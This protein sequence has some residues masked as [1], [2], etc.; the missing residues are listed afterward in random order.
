MR[1]CLW[2]L[3][4]LL[5]RRVNTPAGADGSRLSS[6]GDVSRGPAA[7]ARATRR[8]RHGLDAGD[9]A[10]VNTMV[11]NLYSKCFGLLLERV[12]SREGFLRPPDRKTLELVHHELCQKYRQHVPISH[13]WVG[14]SNV[15]HFLVLQKT[16]VL[17]PKTLTWEATLVDLPMHLHLDLDRVTSLTI[18]RGIRQ[19]LGGTWFPA[20]RLRNL[21]S[22]TLDDTFDQ[23]MGGDVFPVTL[24]VL[25]F[26]DKFNKSTADMVFP[27]SLKKLQFGKAF[28]QP[29]ARGIL[30]PSLEWLEFH[31]HGKFNQHIDNVGLPDRMRHLSLGGRYNRSIRGPWLEQ[32]KLTHL[33][34]S[35][36]TQNVY[37]VSWPRNLTDVGMGGLFLNRL[38]DMALPPSVVRMEFAGRFNQSLVGVPWPP[39]LEELH[40]RYCEFRRSLV[41]DIIRD[42]NDDI[43]GTGPVTL[44]DSLHTLSLGSLFDESLH[45]VTWPASLRKLS[46]G[47]GFTQE[48]LNVAWP[49]SLRHVTLP[50]PARAT[51]ATVNG[52]QITWLWT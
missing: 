12:A 46:F 26:G 38:K 50:G 35:K 51:P 4:H 14:N 41:R 15:A 16:A 5:V 45:G 47:R 18:G 36:H 22:L 31:R 32:S 24:Q 11:S 19:P 48:L 33:D 28:N 39:N 20:T 43:I 9:Q 21:I 7:E 44:P 29:M 13:L 27:R 3:L 52:A 17:R 49:A 30:P 23:P 34:L 2:P 37:R 40:F 10:N 8:A 25:R 42:D 6:S 1:F